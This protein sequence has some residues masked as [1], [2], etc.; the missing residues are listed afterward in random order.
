MVQVWHDERL[1]PATIQT[2]LSFL[3]ELA[4]WMGKPGF[5]RVPAHYGLNLAEVANACGFASQQHLTNAMRRRLGA[6]PQRYR[7]SQ[8]ARNAA[9]GRPGCLDSSS[10]G[11]GAV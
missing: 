3:R 11:N 10:S 9:K 8:R 5:V 4:M 7:E 6:T 2:Y 1:A